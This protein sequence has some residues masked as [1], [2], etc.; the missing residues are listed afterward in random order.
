MLAMLAEFI[1]ITYILG[2]KDHQMGIDW[3]K[4]LVLLPNWYKVE[5]VA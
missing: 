4:W 1:A 2:N 3:V 5:I